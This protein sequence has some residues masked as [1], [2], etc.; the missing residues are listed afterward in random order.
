MFSPDVGLSTVNW[1]A[2]RTLD[3]FQLYEVTVDLRDSGDL[4]INECD[5][6]YLDVRTQWTWST[7][8]QCDN[9]PSPT[10]NVINRVYK[11]AGQGGGTCSIF[12]SLSFE[13]D[14]TI[15]IIG[16]EQDAIKASYYIDMNYNTLD[17]GLGNV[18]ETGGF[19]NNWGTGNIGVRKSS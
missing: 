14:A 1:H 16:L 12:Y 2:E 6:I 3:S 4:V 17:V 7:E 13:G 15:T 9:V 19:N 11:T 8:F 10:A 18:T 5:S